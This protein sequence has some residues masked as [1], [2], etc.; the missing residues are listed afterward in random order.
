V[1]T[2]FNQAG[3]ATGRLSSSDPNLQNIPIRSTEGRRIR[4]AFVAPKGCKL[5]SADY[6]QV[7]L[8]VLAHLSGDE[9][10][11]QAFEDDQDIHRIVAAEVF[12]VDLEDVNDDLR[13][14]AKAVNF[15]MIYGQT[16]FG[17]STSLRIPRSKAADF[18]DRYHR[19]FP[20]IRKFLDACIAQA[21]KHAYVETIF[22]RRRAITEIDARNPQRRAAAE[23][24]AI[25][26]VVQGSAADLIKQAMIN[27]A[28]RIADEDRPSKMLL[29][30]H[31]ELLFETPAAAVDDDREMIAAEMS[32]AI[33]MNVP[34]KVDVGVG[35][36]WMDAK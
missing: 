3:T 15:G 30:I 36:N 14:A 8:R 7:E 22:G 24:L 32:G 20:K 13:S 34:L 31:D 2:S 9:T 28:R 11:T 25:N 27:I 18:I 17:L 23:R 35:P 6:S 26:S 33:E 10:L 4:S 29:Q 1:H 5:I 19:R 21:K 16:A 12:E